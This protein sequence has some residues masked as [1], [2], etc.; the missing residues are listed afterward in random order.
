MDIPEAGKPLDD[1]VA[2]PADEPDAA[3][4]EALLEHELE[5]EDAALAGEE[6]ELRPLVTRARRAPGPEPHEDPTAPT[7]LPPAPPITHSRGWRRWILR[8]FVVSLLIAGAGTVAYA[9]SRIVTDDGASG[10]R[11]P[12][13]GVLMPDDAH[14]RDVANQL[15]ARKRPEKL[16]GMT[17]VGAGG[18]VTVIRYHPGAPSFLSS[19]LNPNALQVIARAIGLHS[20]KAI[21]VDELRL[22]VLRRTGRQRWRLR[23]TQDG[24]TW[25]AVVNPNGTDLRLIPVNDR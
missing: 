1:Q 6:E 18:K 10:G 24:R 14:F 4:D 15:L 23:G 20:D 7:I 21:T 3:R 5:E 11:K 16:R 8:L 25:R 13:F 22:E 19:Y 17:I 9:A 2:A 12:V